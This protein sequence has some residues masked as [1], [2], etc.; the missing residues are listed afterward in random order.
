MFWTPSIYSFHRGTSCIILSSFL[1]LIILGLSL[2]SLK[3]PGLRVVGLV[4]NEVR[5]VPGGKEPTVPLGNLVHFYI[6]SSQH[7]VWP[8]YLLR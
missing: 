8:K 1:H 6:H 5:V 2:I 3:N 4:W 7:I